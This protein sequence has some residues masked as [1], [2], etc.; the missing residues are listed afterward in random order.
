MDM[1]PEV[2]GPMVILMPLVVLMITA[3]PMF[4]VSGAESY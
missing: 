4:Q 3:R 2:C 1:Y